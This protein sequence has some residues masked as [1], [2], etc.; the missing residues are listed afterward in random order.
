MIDELPNQFVNWMVV[1]GRKIP[2]GM[3]GRAIDPHDSANWLSHRAAITTGLNVG[4]VLTMD[5]PWFFLDMDKCLDDNGQWRS[6]AAALFTS[7]SGAWGEVSQSGRGLHIMGRCDKARL[8]DRRN[9]W[10]G[11]LEFYTHS[12]FIAMVGGWQRIGGV[13]RDVDWTG[14]IL[15]VVPQREFLGD[16]PDGRDPAYTG[17]EDDETLIRMMLRSG[18]SAAAFGQGVAL[19][20]LWNADS[21]VLAARYPDAENEG[22]D[23]SSADMALMSHLAFWTGRDMPRMDRLFRKSA[24]VRD[25]YISRD[26]YRRETIQKA[27]RLCSNVYSVKKPVLEITGE[28]QAGGG[29]REVFLSIPEMVTH[30]EG[31]VYIR[32][33]HKIFVPDGA[34]LKPEQFNVEYGG[35]YFTMMADGTKPTR[36]AFEAFT[37]N[38]CH[39]FPRAVSTCFRPDLPG[40]H[41]TEDRRVNIYVPPNV[42]M[43]EGDVSRFTDFLA[44]ILPNQNDRDILIHYIAAVIQYP[45]KKFQWAPVLQ[46]TEGNGKTLVSSCVS[47]AVGEM[48]CHSPRASQLGEKYNSYIE[49]KMFITVEEVHMGG[50]REML[51]EL[52]P[53]ITNSKIE[54]RAMRE[55]KV[56]IDNVAN[57]FFCTNFKDAV[58]K[59]KNDRRYAI[60]YTAQQSAEDLERDGMDGTYFPKLYDWLRS[61]GGYSHVAYWLK[62][63]P[64]RDDLNPALRAH[65]APLTTSTAHAVTSSMGPIEQEIHE[66]MLS[67]VQGFRGEWLS[68]WA[69][70]TLLQRRGLRVTRSR[71][72]IIVQDMGYVQFGRAERPVV[73]E[74]NSQ[75]MLWVKAEK[76]SF[77]SFDDYVQSQGY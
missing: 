44:K 68:S 77:A 20:D 52:K 26:D 9:K 58:I 2:V 41:I 61:G 47:Y 67:G 31:C 16:L 60:F 12:R 30:F 76:A 7:F 75:P 37:E 57:W 43:V 54:I 64:L 27:A 1:G 51:D 19:A 23:H 49:G 46:G 14:H 3:D 73:R 63:Y 6:D 69:I 25:K 11:W 28:N 70:D 29:V 65:R 66:A 40:G 48:Y 39:I 24:L 55:D 71:T 74:D 45:G 4:F 53:L 17:P 50:R 15:R 34:M 13:E 62:N 21:A 8:R 10:D 35:H 33:T 5:D 42:E 38:T 56:M 32:D 72:N 59:S 22:F 18:N 36:K